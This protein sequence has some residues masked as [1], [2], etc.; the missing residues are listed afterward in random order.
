M[1]SSA[2]LTCHSTVFFSWPC[3][4]VLDHPLRVSLMPAL[5]CFLL[6]WSHTRG[7]NPFCI[8]AQSLWEAKGKGVAALFGSQGWRSWYGVSS[9]TSQQGICKSVLILVAARSNKWGKKDKLLMIV[10]LSVP[11]RITWSAKLISGRCCNA[12]TCRLSSGF[13]H[14]NVHWFQWNCSWSPKRCKEKVSTFTVQHSYG[15]WCL[16]LKEGYDLWGSRGTESMRCLFP[17][18]EEYLLSQ[19]ADSLLNT[20]LQACSRPFL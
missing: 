4:Q 18:C 9:G 20:I 12:E 5:I 17:L 11:S 14:S 15:R 2:N 6:L 8:G 1:L 3:P 7:T 19:A 16:G 10:F 13:T